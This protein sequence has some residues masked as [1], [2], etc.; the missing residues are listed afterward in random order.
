MKRLLRTSTPIFV[1]VLLV[2]GLSA[3]AIPQSAQAVPQT[4]K[5][6]AHALLVDNTGSMRMQFEQVI[7]LSR[8]IVE[9]AAPRGPISLFTFDS[10]P[11]KSS[12]A[13]VTTKVEWSQDKNLLNRHLDELFV[14]GGQTTLKDSIGQMAEA[15]QSKVNLDKDAFA[16]KMIF[17]VTDGEDRA[18]KLSEKDL[19]IG[20]RENGI[21]V[22][23][24]A[25]VAQ[26]DDDPRALGRTAKTKALA[27]L[28]R[29]TKETGG[30]VVFVNSGA[31]S[32]ADVCDELFKD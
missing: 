15:L 8:E 28:E 29:I 24:V 14:I 7:N 2:F 21:K 20:L 5:Q 1:V 3:Q 18:S 23:A 4:A 16:D 31:I 11:A 26:L 30:R 9:R 25:L 19:I 22:F 17:V 32:A 13:F 12:L 10:R 27:M 6:T